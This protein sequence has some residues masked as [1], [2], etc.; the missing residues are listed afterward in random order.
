MANLNIIDPSGRPHV[1]FLLGRAKLAPKPAHTIPRLELCGAT[2]AV[3]VAEFLQ[4]E[5][6]IEIDQ[7]KYYTDSKVV[8]GYIC[9]SVRRFY[10]YV[11]NRVER[12]RKNSRPEQWNY[13]PT[14]LN[15]A[16][17]A[18]RSVSAV[19]L[20]QTIWFSGPKFLMDQ[21]STNSEEDIDFHLEDLDTDPEIRPEVV[22]LSSNICS[23]R[24]LE[25]RRFECFS[26]WKRLVKTIARLSHIAQIFRK[27][28]QTSSC[29]GWHTCKE[30][31]NALEYERAELFIIRRVQ[32]EVFAEEIKCLKGNRPVSKGSPLF[33]FLQGRKKWQTQK[34][35][36]KEGDL[37]LLK[38]QQTHRIQWP[39]GVITK[40]IA[41]DDGKVRSVGVRI[42]KDGSPKTFL[43]PVTE[44]V[45]IMPASKNSDTV[46]CEGVT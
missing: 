45:L 31:P 26:S 41:S 33:T 15:P 35:N 38:D 22:A 21:S 5:I 19:V 25:V 27:S 11:A 3:E 16:D 28:N 18:T 6:D 46:L 9:N 23:R 8:L 44:T 34:P 24:S 37:V 36:L 32:E 10:V 1:G 40:A 4:N 7:I 30:S 39:V 20:T 13:V 29:H 2:L 43:R 14:G 17:I 12:I 42:V